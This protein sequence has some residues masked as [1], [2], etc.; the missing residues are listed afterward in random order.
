[1]YLGHGRD[2]PL[3]YLSEIEDKRSQHRERLM[4]ELE[5]R[6]TLDSQVK[7]AQSIVDAVKQESKLT[8]KVEV[9]NFPKQ[10]TPEDISKVVQKLD[11]LK[12]ALKPEKLDNSN[13][14]SALSELKT[15]LNSLPKKFPELPKPK[16]EVS[17]KNLSEF[18]KYIEPLIKEI[19]ALELKP[20]F[21]PKIE[22]K[23][24]LTTDV[25][26]KPVVEAVE[27]LKTAFLGIKYPE[28]PEVDIQPIIEATKAT[29]KAINS[30]QFPVPN[31]VLPFKSEDG[32][33]TQVTLLDGSI[34]TS[35]PSYATRIDDSTPN[36]IYIGK[37][38]P[39]S[40]PS[41][42]VWQIAKLDT[43]SGLIKTWAG[44]TSNFDKEW[45]ER[46]NLTYS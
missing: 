4:Q 38:L 8:R 43:S 16:D 41:A 33:G 17:V 42:E 21:D 22:V 5:T 31:Y 46:D 12:T 34:P 14:V 44:G 13:I 3:D 26:L 25:D 24:E 39:D 18:K 11:Q 45:D 28:A 7:N 9:Q 15:V 35:S 19:K 10:A 30:L 27:E 2:R 20:V 6:E 1:M 23:P 29:T 32:D 37:A 40:L 36:T